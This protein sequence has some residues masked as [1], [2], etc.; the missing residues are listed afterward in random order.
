MAFALRNGT[1]LTY[2]GHSTF[3]L[4]TPGG[5]RLLIDPWVMNN[6]R[7]PA[8]KKDVGSLDRMLITHGHYDHICDAV[9][10]AKA[11]SPKTYANYE[12]CVWLESKGVE[13]TQ[14][15]NKGGT[16][17]DGGVAV[18]MVHAD[19]SCGI[20]DGD[21][22]IYGGEAGGY[23]VELEDGMKIYH[24]GD[25]AVFGDMMLIAEIYRPDVALL[26]IGDRFV[27]SPREA[28]HA[29]RLLGAPLVVPMHF[30]T[31][32]QLTGTPEAFRIELDTLGV[33][34]EVVVLEPGETLGA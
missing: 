24:A 17:R 27:M 13:N 19:H 20:T 8:D 31:F 10:I 2:L 15:M 22:I 1:Q 16:I 28:A 33:V 6:P 18:T 32:P 9:E 11:T 4:V 21:H 5:E 34:T 23:I 30:G 26:P 25:T 12:T 14:P 29:A 3:H 7:T